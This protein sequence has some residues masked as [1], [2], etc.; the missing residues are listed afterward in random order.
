MSW[1]FGTVRAGACDLSA[2]TSWGGRG[3]HVRLLPSSWEK[4]L[5]GEPRPGWGLWV[6]VIRCLRWEGEGKLGSAER[7]G[8]LLPPW[9]P[10]CV[11]APRRPFATEP[12]S[13]QNPDEAPICLS[14]SNRN[15]ARLHRGSPT[16]TPVE[17]H[18]PISSPSTGESEAR[19]DGRLDRRRHTASCTPS[20]IPVPWGSGRAHRPAEGL[21]LLPVPS[22]TWAPFHLWP[23]ASRSL[24]ESQATPLPPSPLARGFCSL[25]LTQTKI[26]LAAGL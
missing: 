17:P 2:A 23:G 4:S 10:C 26:N 24:H 15:G 9:V 19:R 8:E 25:L 16:P 13:E 6:D 1:E 3:S 20:P 18:G 12:C 22:R 11:P 5:P 7:G 21:T 14:Y